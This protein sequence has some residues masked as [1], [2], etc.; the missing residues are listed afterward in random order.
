M[1]AL[2]GDLTPTII[3]KLRAGD[4]E[5][6]RLLDSAYREAMVRFA[7]RLGLSRQ[8]R[9]GARLGPE[10][11]EVLRL[12]YTEGLSRQEISEVLDVPVSTSPSRR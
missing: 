5:A 7:R 4:D 2:Q 9:G 6:G 10:H 8:R 1:S 11:Q 12:R 3:V